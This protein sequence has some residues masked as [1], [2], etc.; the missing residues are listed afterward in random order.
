MALNIIDTDYGDDI[1]LDKDKFYL[2]R[3]TDNLI[4]QL[5][6]RLTTQTGS[7][8]W[9]PTEGIDMRDYINK[10]MSDDDLDNL[11][12]LITKELKRDERID[13]VEVTLTFLYG[14][15]SLKVEIKVFLIAGETF[16][17]VLNVKDLTVDLLKVEA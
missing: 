8:F 14:S 2:L 12:F 10:K 13:D 11:K 16:K 5:M 3:G 6:R 15:F 17:L 9:A 1:A 4:R 7:L